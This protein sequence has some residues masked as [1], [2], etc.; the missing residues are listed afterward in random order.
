VKPY[1]TFSGRAKGLSTFCREECLG[2][3]AKRVVEAEKGIERRR[4]EK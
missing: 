2:R 3:G 1:P 4:V